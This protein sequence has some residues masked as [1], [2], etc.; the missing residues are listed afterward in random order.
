MKK[1]RCLGLFVFFTDILIILLCVY[2]IPERQRI[3]FYESRINSAV[4]YSIIFCGINVFN[5]V[6]F[7]FYKIY[8]PYLAKKTI[9]AYFVFILL[10]LFILWRT[11]A[12]SNHVAFSYQYILFLFVYIPILTS[13]SRLFF[14]LVRKKLRIMNPE[15]LH[16]LL[17]I[18]DTKL[19]NLI[20]YQM[21][22]K[23]RT[24]YKLV[25]F[26]S[27]DIPE[28][29]DI[30]S[31]CLG[32]IE[33]VKI[34]NNFKYVH[35]ILCSLG[36][37]NRNPVIQQVLNDADNNMAKVHFVETDFVYNNQTMILDYNSI[38]P[39]F[40]TRKEPLDDD[41]NFIIKRFFDLIIA[42]LV[43]VLILSWLIPI[44]G[45]LI[46]LESK[47][48]VFFIQKRTGYNNHEFNCLKFRSMYV[49]DKCDKVQ[50][51]KNDKRTTK[52]GRFLR[53]TNLDEMPQFINVLKGEMSIVGPRPHMV[54]HTEYY[55][56]EIEKYM[57]RQYVLPGITGW[58]QVMGCR[59]ETKKEEDMARRVHHDIWYLE[60]WTIWLDLKIIVL[61][62]IQVIKGDPKAY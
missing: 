37:Y 60:N 10:I 27:D 1:N 44:I 26:Y 4:F 57:V 14:I 31:L 59:G 42:F 23:M 18:G 17:V 13:L 33:D 39:V 54:A 8:S 50:A 25:G 22:S 19:V 32:K 58:A 7:S 38:M 56:K 36:I 46:K 11:N 49:N 52:I 20:Y 9:Q 34:N 41:K 12:E 55:S 43:N 61:T 53:K 35:Y 40:S 45:L 62:I 21:A 16:N 2:L 48:P 15:R 29:K 24:D 5:N 6:Y 3:F 51:T 28:E 47:G 30:A